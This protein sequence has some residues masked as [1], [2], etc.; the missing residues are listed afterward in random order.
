MDSATAGSDQFV[1]CIFANVD[2]SHFSTI[3]CL[4]YLFHRN[5]FLRR[6]LTKQGCVSSG[7]ESFASTTAITAAGDGISPS[8]VQSVQL[9]QPLM[10]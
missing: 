8:M 10:V 4:F 3:V 1:L 7:T 6:Y 5:V 9:Q 2:D